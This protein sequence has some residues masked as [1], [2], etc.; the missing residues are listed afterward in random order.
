[1]LVHDPR[2]WVAVAC[3]VSLGLAALTRSVLWP[4]PLVLC[5]LLVVL[6]R[7][8]LVRRLALPLLVFA[9]YAVVVA[10][11]AVR[12]TRLQGVVT[13]VDT[14]GGM[15]LRMGNYEYTPD[16]RMW[17]AVALTGE[18]S[19]VNGLA[20]APPGEPMTEGR[21]EKWAQRK[22]IEYMR[23]H[24]GDTLRRAFIKF[25]D[26]WGLEREFI[27]GVQSGLFAPPRWFEVDC[28]A[29]HRVRLRCR[30]H[31]RRCRN[32]A[33]G[34][35]RSPD[36][37]PAAPSG[38]RDH[39]RPHDRVRPLALPPAADS[40]SRA[41][42]RGLPD[43]T[44]AVVPVGSTPDVDRRDVTVTALVAIW[45]RQVAFVDLAR[46]SALLHHVG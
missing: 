26:F 3:G 39:W 1:M 35:R 19:W 10:P 5:P 7:A 36:A 8:G 4:L 27:A 29:S 43:H 34:A 17:D 22:A 40:D 24:P 11:W 23:D 28:L 46:I 14:M 44:R 25:A 21:K 12:N 32:L 42:R 9:G 41:V 6:L 37:H 45:I 2:A 16:D 30:R 31:R 13:I 15:N 18:K 33:L 20:P 38:R